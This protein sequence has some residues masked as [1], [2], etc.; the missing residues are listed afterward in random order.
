[1]RSDW[2]TTGWKRRHIIIVFTDASAIPLDKGNH[3]PDAPKELK[4]LQDWWDNGVPGGNMEANARRMIIFAPDAQPW[5]I[6]QG[7]DLVDFFPS[8]AGK[9]C[10][11][12]DME[13][14]IDD[15][16]VIGLLCRMKLDK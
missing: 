9:G 14:I 4:E 15:K 2:C 16:L 12:L 11:D 7:W 8:A 10:G 3:L 1:M 5:N 6:M 13:K